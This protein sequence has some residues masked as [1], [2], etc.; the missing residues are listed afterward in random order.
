LV[1][2]GD[3][4]SPFNVQIGKTQFWNCGT[5]M[6]RKSDERDY[7]PQIGMLMSDGSMKAHYLDTSQ[8]KC[9]DVAEAKELEKV[10]DMDLSD[11]IEGLG[12]LGECALDFGEAMKQQLARNPANKRVRLILWKAMEK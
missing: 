12:Q 9:L 8:D 2:S 10:P 11:L 7:Q 4:H 6:R 5:F 3:N 1:V